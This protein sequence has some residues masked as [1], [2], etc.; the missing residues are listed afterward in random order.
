MVL[1]QDH[2]VCAVSA[3]QTYTALSELLPP[4]TQ[5]YCTLSQGERIG[6]ILFSHILSQRGQNKPVQKLEPFK[7]PAT[8]FVVQELENRVRSNNKLA[9]IK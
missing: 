5:T 8:S 9:T 2:F 4:Y 3:L 6:I 1:L 7:H